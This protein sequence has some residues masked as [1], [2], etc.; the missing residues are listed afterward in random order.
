MRKIYSSQR[1]E[2]IDRVIAL[3]NAANIA[4][5]LTNR[6]VY[7]SRP[8]QRF[9]YTQRNDQEHWPSVW[10]VKADDQV[11]ARELLRAAGLEPATRYADELASARR[12]ERHSAMGVAARLRLI[13]MAALAGSITLLALHYLGWL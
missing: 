12:G 13:V 2:N 5:H 1:N 10:I 4:T 6:S 11:R 8:Y 7:K 3:L 9:S